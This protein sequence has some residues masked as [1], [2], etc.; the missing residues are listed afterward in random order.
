MSN[1]NTEEQIKKLNYN[2]GITN[3]QKVDE[4]K[5]QNIE[6]IPDDKDL[7][8]KIEKDKDKNKKAVDKAKPKLIIKIPKPFVMGY[9]II[10]IGAFLKGLLGKLLSMLSGLLMGLLMAKLA[11]LLGDLLEKLASEKGNIS[12]SDMTNAL[13]SI[14]MTDVMTELIDQENLMELNKMLSDSGITTGSTTGE[15]IF[16]LQNE[17]DSTGTYS[18]DNITIEGET[19]NTIPTPTKKNN[20]NEIYSF[21]KRGRSDL[22]DSDEA[23]DRL[24][25]NSS[26]RRTIN[27]PNYGKYW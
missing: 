13:N 6:D 16:N 17:I 2:L 20:K 23:N 24:T 4:F 3:I 11:E 22:L 7:K 12:T 26:S 1:I 8:D 10:D 21:N 5:K 25:N 18:N 19:K 15:I 14:N 27:N 9:F